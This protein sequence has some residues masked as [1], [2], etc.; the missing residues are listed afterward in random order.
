[1]S[2]LARP[3]DPPPARE[4]RSPFAVTLAIGAAAGIGLGAFALLADSRASLLASLA[5]LA[6]VAA[7]G[8]VVTAALARRA[9][10]LQSQVGRTADGL[11]GLQRAA[12]LAQMS[13]AMTHEV[14]NPVACLVGLAQVAKLKVDDPELLGPLLD[15]IED[16]AQACRRVIERFLD[17]ARG[18][19]GEP[20]LIDVNAVAGNAYG[21]LKH[22]LRSRA[23][24]V[25]L[26]LEP[27]LPSVLGAEVEL[28]QVIVNLLLNAEQALAGGG[29]VVIKT[30][31]HGDSVEIEVCDN[32]PGIRQDALP[33]IFE[34]F[35]TTKGEGTGLGLA[36]CSQIAAQ[37]G[38][39]LSARSDAGDGATF[40]LRL[41]AAERRA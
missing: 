4:G 24:E 5:I 29:A 40:V 25:S 30:R 7:L 3:D 33:H 9:A 17:I 15:Q 16:S 20:S 1:M 35:F 10:G 11:T 6:V 12:A 38:G 21:M 41:P 31:T 13:T 32:G 8:A 19:R 22:H 36:I 2:L 39:T 26:D 27:E 37:H 14:R 18:S 34:P 23:V 28:N